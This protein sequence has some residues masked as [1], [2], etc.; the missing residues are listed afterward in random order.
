MNMMKTSLTTLLLAT[1]TWAAA[2][3]ETTGDLA[4]DFA[5][6]AAEWKSRPLWFWNGPLDK[7]RTTEVMER[8]VASGYH[9]FGILPT[10]AMGVPF[11]SPEFLAHYKHAVDTAARL[12]Q[13]M[14]LYD[15]F[16]FPS[17]SA[18]GLLR[19]R[20]PEALS[21]R[22]DMVETSVAGP[23]V[24]ALDLPKGELMAAVAMNTATLERLDLATHISNGRLSWA[25]PAGTWRVMFFACVSDGAGGLV[26]YL[27]PEAVKKFVSL[28]YEQ[29]YR[30]FPE[31]FGK[32][33]DSAFY[34][35]P[36]FHWVQGGRAWTPSFNQRFAKRYGRSPVLLYPAL[37]HDIGADTPAARNQLFGL[38][39][40][41][42]ATGFIKTLA[43]WCRDHGIELTGH[44]DQEEI[45]NPVGLCGDLIKSFEH[46][47]IPGLDQVFAYGRGSRMYKV[48]SSAAVNYGRRRVMTECY[49]AMQLP[50]ANLYREAMDQFAKGV[51]LM[52]PHAVWYQTNAIIFPPELSWRTE[53]YASVLPAYNDYVGRLQRVL[54]QGRPVVDI[55]V[56]YP[57]AGLQAAYHFGAG[58]PYEGGVIPDWAEY[59]TL[60][61][62][63]S[64][65]LRH[66]FTFLHPE[67]LDARC[68]LERD[69][70]R[71]EHPEIFQNYRVLILPGSSTISAANL[72]KVKQFFDAGGK[73]IATTRLPDQSAEFGQIAE[74]RA[75]IRH[76]FG[77]E[78]L[79]L[80][81]ENR[82]TTRVT[83]SSVWA[84][85][86]HDAA[87]ACDGD[88]DTRW[89]ARDGMRT[90]QW[91]EVDFGVPRTFNRVRLREAFNRAVSHRVEAWDGQGWRVCVS[92]DRMGADRLHTFAPVTAT[93]VRLVIDAVRSDTPS[94]AEFEILDRDGANFALLQ[95]RSS[96]LTVH[97]NERG[98][99]AWF[100]ETPR[101]AALAGVLAEAVPSPDVAWVNPPLVKGGNLTYLHK[102]IGGR[103]FYF[104][105][106]SSDSVVSTPVRLRGAW[107]LERW[108]PHTG[109]ILPQPAQVQGGAT[110]LLLELPPVT[111]VFIVGQKP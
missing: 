95:P 29:Y 74:V 60:G 89:N 72:E 81:P 93:R 22:L 40:E 14:C 100:V 57:I 61:E 62:R 24:V 2:Q 12:G 86:G 21:K 104:F 101:A 92:G 27:D 102:E 3:A 54:Q 85:G 88:P 43:D 46:Q 48:V 96:R 37:W 87:L 31:H 34:D 53:P 109:R 7:V 15:E 106:N 9:G 73:V 71:L 91:L 20:Y 103:E 25:A 64:L 111:S 4:R 77:A 108:D 50:V 107:R 1:C 6:P 79:A 63:L 69:T 36:T 32:T 56:L 98:G 78:A 83:A 105:A 84:A 33:I 13:K 26:D 23:A 82:P 42:F 38:R 10:K 41:L 70:L 30:A 16:W 47:P 68:R 58:K 45:V 17:G 110:A 5:T 28:T 65:E 19:Q 51:N 97:R 99:A 44:V 67:T 76:I 8:S 75:A 55:A 39:A 52:V 18:G 66:D 90:N 11:M 35:E 59:M 80:P 49:G 94:I